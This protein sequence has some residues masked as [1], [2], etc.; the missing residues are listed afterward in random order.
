MTALIASVAL[1]L[2]SPVHSNFKCQ[3]ECSAWRACNQGS[4]AGCIRRSALKW[5]VSHATMR[6]RAWCESRMN[7]GAYNRGS[8]ASGLYQFLP[9]TWRTTPYRRRS[10]WRA[11]WN[12]LA[13]G[14]M[15]SV[16]RGGEWS[17]R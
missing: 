4:V 12:A 5:N 11:K 16:G 7:P 3:A 8:G 1:V 9:S 6:R 2:S 17:C 15:E 13:A 14:W 10:V